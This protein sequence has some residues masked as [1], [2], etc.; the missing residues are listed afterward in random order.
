M[1][2][3]YA[4]FGNPVEHSMSPQLHS[5]F[6]KTTS[7]DMEYGKILVEENSFVKTADEF[8]RNGG[9]GC[10]VTVPCKM[11]AYSYADH[12][13]DYA[14]MAGA[15]NTLKL[16][17]DGS[18]LGDNTDGRG[19]CEDL[20]RLN[21]PLRSSKLLIIGAGGASRGIIKP[22]LET[23]VESVTIVNRTLSKAQDIASLFEDKVSAVTFDNTDDCYDV[24]INAT[25]AS[26]Q[27]VLPPLEDRIIARARFVYDL[28]YRKGGST[29]FTERA[30]SLGVNCSYDGF[31]M[32]VGQAVLSFELWRGCRPDFASA[33]EYF[34]NDKNQDRR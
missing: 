3:K 14:K 12:L 19:L 31:G 30:K 21:C 20:K 34:A 22:L 2:D 32:L 29:I 11:D 6:A 9:R 24:I 10:N 15:V 27:N 23:G 7:Q 8:F 5:Y 33:I 28:M 25:S 4:V 13:S 17:D 18:I 1:T 26:L 16:L